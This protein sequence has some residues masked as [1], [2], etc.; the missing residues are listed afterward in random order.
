MQANQANQHYGERRR[1]SSVFSKKLFVMLTP[2]FRR[3]QQAAQGH[4]RSRPQSQDQDRSQVQTRSRSHAQTRLRRILATHRRR[5]VNIIL[6]IFRTDS[7]IAIITLLRD[8]SQLRLSRV[9]RSITINGEER[10]HEFSVMARL[11]N[12]ERRFLAEIPVEVAVPESR[13]PEDL[14]V[15]HG[16][17]VD[18]GED[19]DDDDSDSD[20]EDEQPVQLD[21][22]SSLALLRALSETSEGRAL[23]RRLSVTMQSAPLAVRSYDPALEDANEDVDNRTSTARLRP[24]SSS[25]PNAVSP[26]AL[27]ARREDFRR[28]RRTT[29]QPDPPQGRL[30]RP[31]FQHSQMYRPS[32][33][34]HARSPTLTGASFPSP[35]TLAAIEE[36]FGSWR[37]GPTQPEPREGSIYNP[38]LLSS[39]SSSDDIEHRTSTLPLRASS[40]RMSERRI[41]RRLLRTEDSIWRGQ[42]DPEL[43]SAFRGITYRF[44]RDAEELERN[45]IGP[46]TTAVLR[47][48]GLELAD[49]VRM[50]RERSERE[51][52]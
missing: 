45:G 11:Y 31:F 17:V 34:I 42:V 19:G 50:L 30:Y 6:T 16:E 1:Y 44:H 33:P 21:H 39:S 14:R 51:R 49:V 23:L 37:S 2:C 41:Q 38:Y 47:R 15:E 43:R 52:E 8:N 3:R 40:S 29:T 25:Q 7:Q 32:S 13:L 10:T 24:S 12:P 20:E 28:W 22:Q 35:S 36:E 5:I 9:A 46:Q 27:Q 4:A 26:G 48:P 18:E